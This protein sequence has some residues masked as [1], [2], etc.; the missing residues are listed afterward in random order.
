MQ[1]LNMFEPAE[2]KSK[3]EEQIQ[4]LKYIPNYISK[5]D[6]QEL[7]DIIDKQPWLTDLKRRVQHYGY[8]YDYRNRAVDR[9]QYLGPLP[10]WIN[11]LSQRL[12]EDSIFK[13]QP[14]QVIIN[15]Y[16][17]GQ[18]IAPHIDC[19]PCF[20]DTICSLSLG[21]SC[22]MEFLKDLSKSSLML[23]P[24]SLLVLSG[25]ARYKWMHGISARKSDHYNGNKFWRERRVS[26]TFRKVIF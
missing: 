11:A 2:V 25:D 7:L 15:E 17:P 18:G 26:L 8:K 14:D 12:Y 23:E 9:G 22:M 10:E 6:E 16:L 19:E 1:Q 24:C 13:V 4:G 21:S 3:L 20:E 5:K